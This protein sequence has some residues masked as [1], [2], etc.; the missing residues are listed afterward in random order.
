MPMRGVS[1]G[2]S[3]AIRSAPLVAAGWRGHPAC[4]VIVVILG[5]GTGPAAATALFESTVELTATLSLANGAQLASLGFASSDSFYDAATLVGIGGGFRV[6]AAT[7]AVDRAFTPPR[8]Y[9][10]AAQG[11]GIAGLIFSDDAAAMNYPQVVNPARNGIATAGGTPSGSGTSFTMSTRISGVAYPTSGSAYAELT[12]EPTTIFQNLS[13]S[14]LDIVWTLNYTLTASARVNDRRREDAF[15]EAQIFAAFGSRLATCGAS[16]C[17]VKD[18]AAADP[19]ID[20]PESAVA[21]R[22]SPR[23][24]AGTKIFGVQLAPGASDS[25]KVAITQYGNAVVPA[26]TALPLF[27]VGLTALMAVGRARRIR[28]SCNA[29]AV[30]V[31][32]RDTSSHRLAGSPAQ[33]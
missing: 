10:Q 9:D 31:H 23:P 14:V 32:E 4:A 3:R 25:F 29:A 26:P 11:G 18:I 8:P 22:P 20:P 2:S 28:G 21:I 24:V 27:V 19:P 6:K 5:I 17:L 15:V 30:L 7:L 16:R 1:F 13:S 12:W 33:S